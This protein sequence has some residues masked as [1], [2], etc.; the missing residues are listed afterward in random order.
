MKVNPNNNRHEKPRQDDPLS[1][2]EEFECCAVCGTLTGVPV[3]LP[4][5]FRDHYEVGFGQLCVN[6]YREYW[7]ED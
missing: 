1:R 6:C 4:I 2:Q 7:K 5:E 3:S